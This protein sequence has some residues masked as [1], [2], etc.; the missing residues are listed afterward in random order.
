MFGA[1]VR[2]SV[3]LFENMRPELP[4]PPKMISAV[5]PDSACRVWLPEKIRSEKLA[6]PS[7]VIFLPF[8]SGRPFFTITW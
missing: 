7:S 5:P 2:I 3:V 6:E 1:M 4:V 8:F